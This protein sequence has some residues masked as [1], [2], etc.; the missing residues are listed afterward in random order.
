MGCLLMGLM[1]RIT[2][3]IEIFFDDII[4]YVYILLRFVEVGLYNAQLLFLN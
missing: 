4:F 2:M 1:M 3:V